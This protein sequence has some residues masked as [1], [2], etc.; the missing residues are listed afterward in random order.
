MTPPYGSS[1]PPYG[2]SDPPYG[3]ADQIREGVELLAVA[4]KFF[5]ARYYSG[6]DA[7]RLISIVSTGE[8]FLT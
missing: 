4:A 6:D 8:N 7:A 1:D 2:S 5:D 3:P